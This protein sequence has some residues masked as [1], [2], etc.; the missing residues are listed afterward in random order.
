MFIIFKYKIIGVNII[1]AVIIFT[2]IILYLNI[3]NKIEFKD[4]LIEANG[5]IFDLIIFGILLTTYEI[6]REKKDKIQR[7]KE[8]LDDYRGW[9]EDEAAYRVAGLIKRLYNEGI[10]YVEVSNLN[11]AGCHPDLFKKIVKNS[12]KNHPK[13]YWKV[14][15][16]SADL[17]DT[18]LFFITFIKSDLSGTNLQCLDLRKT[19]FFN[20]CNLIAAKLDGAIVVKEWFTVL[21]K[22]FKVEGVDWIK[23]NYSLIPYNNDCKVLLKS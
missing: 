9:A 13:T 12:A 10:N 17:R 14:N 20:G 22:E 18:D 4:V 21:E 15:L 3:I 19:C 8:E 6:V 1:T 23:E 2:P 11:L 5:L 7:Y 16:R